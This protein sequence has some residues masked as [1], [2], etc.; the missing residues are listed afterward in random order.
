MGI[1]C[2]YIRWKR[3]TNL[4]SLTPN[5]ARRLTQFGRDYHRRDSGT[6]SR[7]RFFLSGAGYNGEVA[8]VRAYYGDRSAGVDEFYR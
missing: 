4:C 6:Q 1:T 8:E 7:M 3:Q 5:D 2:E